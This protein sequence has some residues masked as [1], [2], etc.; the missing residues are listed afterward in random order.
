MKKILIGSL[1]SFI[2]LFSTGCNN[3]STNEKVNKVKDNNSGTLVCTKSETDEDNM[4]TDDTIKIQYK[5]NIV[6]KVESSTIIQTLPEYIDMS[7]SL[8]QTLAEQFNEVNGLNYKV[9]K[10]DDS[11]IETLISVDYDK[12]DVDKLNKLLSTDDDEEEN[13]TFIN[14]IKNKNL[15]LDEYK[16][17]NL[18]G[19][20]CK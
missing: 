15:T 2:V 4:T 20:S 16:S 3:N 10:K 9:S 7:I 5:N 1:I 17:Q 19:Y 13:N 18:D 14:S 6:K 11:H 12:I 8:S